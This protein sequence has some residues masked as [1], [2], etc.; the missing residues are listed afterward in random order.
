MTLATATDARV[1][2]PL[3]TRGKATQT[4][5]MS[6]QYVFW[7]YIRVGDSGDEAIQDILANS[8]CGPLGDVRVAQKRTSILAGQVLACQAFMHNFLP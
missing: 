5:S 6:T 2:L 3:M 8:C 7:I 4:S 1:N